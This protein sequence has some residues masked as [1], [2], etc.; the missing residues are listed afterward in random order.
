MN[1]PLFGTSG[2]RGVVNKDLT[3]E[4]CKDV[5]KSLGTMLAPGSAVCLGTD[6][7]L[8]RELIKKAVSEGLTD[9]GVNV[10]NLGIVPTPAVALL[11][12]EMGL[13]AG[14]MI[15]ASHNPPE[16]NGIKLF[17]SD[18][19]GFNRTQEEDLEKIYYSRKFRT[20]KPG[21]VESVP[22]PKDRYFDF[23]QSLVSTSNFN[24]KLKIM[25]DPGNGAASGFASELFDKLG[26]TV[27]PVNDVPDGHFP[28]RSSEPKEDTLQGTIE[29][30]RQK[31]A[32]L[33]VCFDGDAD[34]VVF[35]D[36]KGFLGFN[37]MVAFISRNVVRSSGKTKVATTVET[38]M[39][40]D[41]AIEDLGGTVIRGKV[42]DVYA[43]HLARDNDAALGVESVGVY[44]LPQA[45]YY[46][47]S[48]FA[49][50]TLLGSI[51]EISDIRE[52]IGKL[53]PLHFS[54]DKVSCSNE[55]KLQAMRQVSNKVQSLKPLSVNR[56]DGLRLEFG[57]AWALI[58]ASGTEPAIRVLA[59][60][61]DN[62]R[63]LDLV[64]SG[65]AMVEEAVKGAKS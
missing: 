7:R 3:V 31:D 56:L 26:F 38:G 45:G 27:I 52:F 43:A 65:T 60:S 40:L 55:L 5:G 15:T 54:K 19:I 49:A 47:D 2:V 53:P 44:I 62:K 24:R 11:T 64:K 34:R 46:P 37:E 42:G 57:D 12:R 8:S 33:A 22:H 18:S 28:G 51:T 36:Q 17:N 14:I 48:I 61:R 29:F 39:L 21:M 35:C 16:F 13:N 41:L 6:S 30:L 20:G 23:L 4:L 50:L 10:A 63:T 32:D 1:R 9:A 25:I 58:R 59:E